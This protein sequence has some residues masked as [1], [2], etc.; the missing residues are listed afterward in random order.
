M[1]DVMAVKLKVIK[2]AFG[3]ATLDELEILHRLEKLYLEGVEEGVRIVK[4]KLH[5][6]D[7]SSESPNGR[8]T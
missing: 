7:T 2:A 8:A 4:E 5:P 3:I 6:S 1:I